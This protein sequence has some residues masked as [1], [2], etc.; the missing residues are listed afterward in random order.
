MAIFKMVINDPKT[1]KT[2]Q[3]EIDQSKAVG[4]IGKKIGDKFNGDILGM[5]G[6]MLLI[7]GGTDKDGFPMHNKLNSSGR[8][9]LLLKDSIG[10]NPKDKGVRRRKMVRGNTISEDIVQINTKVVEYGKEDFEKIT[11]GGVGEES[12]DKSEESS[13]ETGEKQEKEKAEKE[14]G[15]ED[16]KDEPSEEKSD[17]SEEKPDEKDDKE[18]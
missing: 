12:T 16:K 3:K 1:R 6:Y 2:F 9:K 17:K 5:K 13:E 18:E 8:K 11:K 7:T 14:A 4:L 10:Y 15:E